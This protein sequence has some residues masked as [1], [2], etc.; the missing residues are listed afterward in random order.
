MVVSVRVGRFRVGRVI[1]GWVSWANNPM[2]L[3]RCPV[4]P[5]C[6]PPGEGFECS[7]S[8]ACIASEALLPET[9]RKVTVLTAL[10]YCASRQVPLTA[11]HMGQML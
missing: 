7:P 6:C 1:V 9:G 3:L 2:R 5:F 11:S 4:P 10:R 8:K